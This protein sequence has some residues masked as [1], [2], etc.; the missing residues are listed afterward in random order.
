MDDTVIIRAGADALSRSNSK[1]VSKKWA[2][3]LVP[4][5]ISKP[6]LVSSLS[7]YMPP[8]L[9]TSTSKLLVLAFTCS[10]ISRTESRSLKSLSTNSTWWLPVLSLIAATVRAPFSGLRPWTKTRAPIAAS[11]SAVFSPTPLVAP[12]T[13]T[14][15]PVMEGP[16]G[17]LTAVVMER[18][19][20]LIFLF[21]HFVHGGFTTR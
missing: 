14:V 9:F 1:W 10:A 19:P 5:V 20:I 8:A 7:L 12:V 3:W 6:S 16:E 18:N 17:L 11:A 2:R 4:K 15:L 21:S 13:N